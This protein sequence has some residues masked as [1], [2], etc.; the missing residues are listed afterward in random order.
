MADGTRSIG[1]DP[2]WGTSS[3]VW[4]CRTPLP[5]PKLRRN[6]K[7]VFKGR[8]NRT[9]QVHWKRQTSL[10]VDLLQ[11]QISIFPQYCPVTP[12]H[13]SPHFQ[14]T[15]SPSSNASPP[16][17][18]CPLIWV[19]N[20]TP[21]NSFHRL[22]ALMIMSPLLLDYS[23]E[24]ATIIAHL[25]KKERSSLSH[26]SSSSP[27]S[28]S[29][30]LQSKEFSL[31]L[32]L[33]FKGLI[34][35]PPYRRSTSCPIMPWRLNSS[36]FLMMSMFAKSKDPSSN[37]FLLGC[38]QHSAKMSITSLTRFSWHDF[39]LT[40]LLFCCL[41]LHQL[42]WN[43]LLCSSNVEGQEREKSKY[44]VH[45]RAAF[46]LGS[47]MIDCFISQNHLPR[48]HINNEHLRTG[49]PKTGRRKNLFAPSCSPVTKGLLQGVLTPPHSP[50]ASTWALSWSASTGK[51]RTEADR[52][53]GSGALSEWQK[54]RMT[55][56]QREPTQSHQERQ[57]KNAKASQR[58]PEVSHKRCL[59]QHPCPLLP[60][61]SLP[62]DISTSVSKTH[63]NVVKR[64]HF[65]PPSPNVCL[66]CLLYLGQ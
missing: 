41:L 39:L 8:R 47:S 44:C 64:E 30:P 58:P 2:Y 22:L 38:L 61:P 3:R 15:Y 42:Y 52:H 19:F 55:E 65:L 32:P 16:M 21:Y 28:L 12:L 49:C 26:T 11:L 57:N 59:I 20:Y 54:D 53:L 34:L 23:H 62:I 50:V 6:E 40:F 29:A 5:C 4:D 25:F 56:S 10:Q 63:I 33:L 36:R 35:Y 43:C 46:L 14:N 24:Y 27:T 66:L 9:K 48:G 1:V 37:P 18:T 31:L 17:P 60:G 13:T 45:Y 51:P 7:P